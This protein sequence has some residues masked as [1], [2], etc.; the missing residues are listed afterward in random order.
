MRY[1]FLVADIVI[2]IFLSKDSY[3]NTP[4][5]FVFDSEV[6]SSEDE[7][8]IYFNIIFYFIIYFEDYII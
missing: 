3:S 1:P 2:K 5:A 7:L 6:I 8:Q 4:S